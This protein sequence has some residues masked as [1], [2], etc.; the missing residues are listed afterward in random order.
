MAHKTKPIKPRRDVMA[1]VHCRVFYAKIGKAS[2][3]VALPKEADK[4]VQ[5]TGTSVGSR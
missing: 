4:M 2:R 1:F 5:Q 3:W